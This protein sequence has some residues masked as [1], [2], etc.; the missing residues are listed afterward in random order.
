M[1]HSKPLFFIFVFSIHSWQ[2]TNVQYINKFLPM[3]G[4]EP[5]T[6]GIGSNRS[7][8]WAT[9]TAQQDTFYTSKIEHELTHFHTTDLQA[10]FHSMD[11]S[12]DSFQWLCYSFIDEVSFRLSNFLLRFMGDDDLCQVRSRYLDMSSPQSSKTQLNVFKLATT[13]SRKSRTLT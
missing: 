5:W 8:N 3:T 2:K 4:F 11:F 9:A 6:S 7:T 13:F 1:G 10:G 12:I